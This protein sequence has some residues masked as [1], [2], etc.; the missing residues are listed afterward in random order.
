MVGMQG[1]RRMERRRNCRQSRR[2]RCRFLA[3]ARVGQ[4]G[5]ITQARQPLG[6]DIGRPLLNYGCPLGST[7]R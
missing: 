2:N 4:R 5:R 3:G 1:R 7:L 6:Q